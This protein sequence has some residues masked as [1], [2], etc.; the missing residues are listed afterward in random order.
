MTLSKDK[1]KQR[2]TEGMCQVKFTKK[3]GSE[4][5]MI[6]TLQPS[7]VPAPKTDNPRP[8]PEHLVRCWSIGEQGWRSFD[9]SRLISID[10]IA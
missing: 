10:K 5:I 8:E 4:R 6:A 9:M 2:L 3:D 7:M 1:V